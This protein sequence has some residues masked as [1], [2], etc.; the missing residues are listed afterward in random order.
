M[1]Y[2]VAV[3]Q[4]LRGV[5]VLK[6]R[7]SSKTEFGPMPFPL[8]HYLRCDKYNVIWP[9]QIRTISDFQAMPGV[10]FSKKLADNHYFYVSW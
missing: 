4:T 10:D 8:R 7:E 1:I 2:E 3:I 6:A 9:E 5:Q